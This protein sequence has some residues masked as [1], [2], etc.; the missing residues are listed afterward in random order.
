MFACILPFSPGFYPMDVRAGGRTESPGNQPRSPILF[1][2]WYRDKVIQVA[3]A[4]G[5]D[6]PRSLKLAIGTRDV[7][8]R[9]FASQPLVM[10]ARSVKLVYFPLFTRETRAGEQKSSDRVFVVDG[11]SS[12]FVDSSPVQ[13]LDGSLSPSLEDFLTAPGDSVH[14]RYRIAPGNSLRISCLPREIM[15]QDRAITA[16]DPGGGF[17]RPLDRSALINIDLPADYR[18][19]IIQM[20]EGDLCF[21]AGPGEGAEI[22]VRYTVPEIKTCAVVRISETQYEFQPNGGVR[23]GTGTG[24]VFMIYNPKTMKLVPLRELSREDEVS[25]TSKIILPK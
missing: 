8:E 25:S 7:R 5:G 22:V 16:V 24:V 14:L 4:N 9:L 10:P 13:N 6:T 17:P 19:Q 12:G 20:V 18:S 21:L 1:T 15:V 11:A 3:I 23:Y 2:A